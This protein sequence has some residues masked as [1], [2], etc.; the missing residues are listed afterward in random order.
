MGIKELDKSKAYR[1]DNLDIEQLKQLHK[2]DKI[3][4]TIEDFVEFSQIQAYAYINNYWCFALLKYDYYIDALELFEESKPSEVNIINPT[5]NDK[6]LPNMQ[7]HYDNSNGS[8]YQ[9][10]EEKGLNSY[11]FDIIKRVMRCRKKGL[12]VEDLEKTKF[13][14]DL[15]IQEY[16]HENNA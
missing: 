7:K 3:G 16:N 11:E 2:R 10:C 15:Y 9:F 4:Y 12:F 1:L 5:E 6:V 13:L 8:L 14:I